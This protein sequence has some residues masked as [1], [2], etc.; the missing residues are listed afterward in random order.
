MKLLAN[1]GAFG[2]IFPTPHVF[3]ISQIIFR[4][5]VAKS[6]FFGLHGV[7][8]KHRSSCLGAITVGLFNQEVRGET[9]RNERGRRFS[10]Y[11]YFECA[12]C[13][14]S[15]PPLLPLHRRESTFPTME[16]WAGRSLSDGSNDRTERQMGRIQQ[17]DF[18]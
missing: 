3:G 12:Y 16:D 14:G 4:T 11:E 2:G 5:H 18:D 15:G 17:D 9:G 7:P 1:T 13:G 8:F 6:L 10:G